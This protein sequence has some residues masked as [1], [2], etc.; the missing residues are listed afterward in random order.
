VL[1]TCTVTATPLNFGSVS[2]LTS[3]LTA[4]ATLT[5]R[6]NAAVPVTV[7]MDNGTVGGGNTGRRMQSAA[8]N[9]IPYDIFRDAGYRLTKP[10]H[11][12][13]NG[14]VERMNRTIKDATVKRFHYESHDQLRQHLADF[15]RGL[16][17]RPPPEDPTGPHALRSHL[18][19]LD[20]RA[21]Q[22][23]P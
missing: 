21:V 19:S 23:H 20:G 15:V 14:Q 8:N 3:P 16:Q 17:L 18:Q 6:C 2:L 7:R 4:T 22:V 12:W 11:P 9:R 13:T 5:L 1:A 10:R